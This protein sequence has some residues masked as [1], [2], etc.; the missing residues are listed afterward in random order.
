[1]TEQHNGTFGNAVLQA[2]VLA[3]QSTVRQCGKF[4]FSV[5]LSKNIFFSLFNAKA[6]TYSQNQLCGELMQ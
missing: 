1:M 3:M 4:W 2:S 5:Y 6:W